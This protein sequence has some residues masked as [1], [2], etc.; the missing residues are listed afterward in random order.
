MDAWHKE[1][2]NK[3]SSLSS[4]W[5]ILPGSRFTAWYPMDLKPL[6]FALGVVEQ[7]K[8]IPGKTLYLI[9][10]PDDDEVFNY[11]SDWSQSVNVSLVTGIPRHSLFR[12]F[13]RFLGQYTENARPV[14]S[15]ALRVLLTYRFW[16]RPAKRAKVIVF[17][18]TL[19]GSSIIESGDHYFGNALDGLP[20]LGNDEILWLYVLGS[21]SEQRIR[22]HMNSIGRRFHSYLEFLTLSDMVRI[23]RACVRVQT[24]LKSLRYQLP[25]LRIGQLENQTFPRR[26]YRKSIRRQFPALEM[27]AYYSVKR[28]LRDSQATTLLYPYEEKGIER[29]I[30]LACKENESDVRTVG[31]AHAAYNKGHLYLRNRGRVG[32]NPPSPDRIAATGPAAKEWASI[33]VGTSAAAVS[34]TAAAQSALASI[35]S[36]ISS[37][38]TQRGNLGAAQNRL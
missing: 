14:L 33:G 25:T 21:F 36:A 8:T 16:N 10:C 15:F 30:L 23:I 6:F 5:W 28:V 7:C 3:A 31:F 2:S 24:S 26:F 34:T 9:G 38:S 32:A 20:G 18:Y 29:A 22:R 27:A 35:D 37:V 17:S 1:L 12:S 13:L 11:L 4:W 19:R